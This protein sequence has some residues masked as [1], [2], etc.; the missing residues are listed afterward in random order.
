VICGAE[1]VGKSTMAV[2]IA[3][4][5]SNDVNALDI[6]LD[7]ETIQEQLAYQPETFLEIITESEG[8]QPVLIDEAGVVAG[9]SEH[10]TKQN[11]IIKKTIQTMGYKQNVYI[12]ILPDFQALDK[13]VRNKVDFKIELYDR[14]KAKVTGIKT[15]FGKMR[16]KEF[17]FFKQPLPAYWMSDFDEDKDNFKD[18]E[19]AAVMDGYDEKEKKFKQ[20]NAEEMLQEL[21]E[22]K[23]DDDEITVE[24]WENL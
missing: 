21:E 11:R 17:D 2:D 23:K 4:K 6:E 22:E 14:G 15:N 18:D 8:R 20:E 5:L 16:S 19:K 24:E 12:F 7:K 1:R 3:W 13:K 10:Q 9:S